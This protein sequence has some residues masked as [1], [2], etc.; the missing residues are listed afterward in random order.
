M[1]TLPSFRK[2]VVLLSAALGFGALA[3]SLA[4]VPG[5]A[6]G[7]QADLEAVKTALQD[8]DADAARDATAS[9]RE[10]ADTIQLAVQGP[11]GV[12]GQWLP[13]V[14]TSVRDARHLGEALDAVVTTA[15][16]GTDA[17]PEV[18]GD[19]ATFFEGGKVDIATL[20]RL[21]VTAEGVKDELDSARTSLSAI[22]GTG[23]AGGQIGEARDVAL[24]Q[25]TP[26]TDTLG[27]M[28]PL[29]HELP[30]LLGADGDRKYLISILNPAEMYFSGGSALSYAPV[31]VSDGR[32]TIGESV[33]TAANP[34]V[35]QPRY[36][37][38]VKGNQFH[39]GRQRVTLAGLAPSW[40]VAGEETL[41]AWR[42]LRGRNMS[43]LIAVDVVTLARLSKITGPMDVPGYG[44]VDSTNLVE[45]LVGSYDDYADSGVQERKAANRALVAL[46]VDR[47]LGT[48]QLPEK[49]RVLA[50]AAAGRHFAVYFRDD[51][52]QATIDDLALSGDLSDTK[53]DYLGVFTQNVVASKTDYWQSRT[54]SS[55]VRLRPDGSARVALEV[56]IHN[57]SAPYAGPGVDTGSGY[58]TRYATLS[59]G[60]FLPRRADVDTVTVDGTP[61]EFNVGDY[62]GRPFVRQTIEFAPQARRTIRLEYDVPAAAVRDDDTL[63]YGLDVDPQGMVRPQS[64]SVRVHLP[65]GF[66]ADELPEG[67][68]A[69]GRGTLTWTDAALDDSPR[70]TLVA[71]SQ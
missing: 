18:A 4:Q 15:E 54:V 12:F 70:F 53:H 6:D 36:W 67:W 39:R 9:A 1:P 56:E 66:T 26:L 13:V 40:P 52:V 41:N 22:E 63:T 10:H 24:E 14:G 61:I 29:M 25:V 51:K 49:A 33:D 32:V 42:A 68:T 5:A 71:R 34:A 11:V 16:L 57:D 23:P 7:A 48:G 46:F 55:D 69:E 50:D 45:T 65:K 47:L 38:K 17:Y 30:A 28:M 31:T 44:R 19:E 62:F 21:V 60:S 35:F 37:R 59:V 58:F 8:G 27:D 43:G 20:E 2:P 64:T 3:V